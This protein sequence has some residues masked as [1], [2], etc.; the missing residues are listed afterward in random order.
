MLLMAHAQIGK[1]HYEK[2]KVWGNYRRHEGSMWKGVGAEDAFYVRNGVGHLLFY[3]YAE[4]LF[5]ARF[6]LEKRNM[7]EDVICAALNTGNFELLK[8]LQSQFPEL[9]TEAVTPW[10]KPNRSEKTFVLAQRM[11]ATMKKSRLAYKFFRLIYNLFC[12]FTKG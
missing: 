1:V 7:M 8:K 9:Y 6:V 5:G 4:K 2:N 10:S 3:T 11:A 12:F